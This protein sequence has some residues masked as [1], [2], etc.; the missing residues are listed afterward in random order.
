MQNLPGEIWKL[1]KAV[2]YY[3]SEQRESPW[4]AAFE[5]V[6]NNSCFFRT[7]NGICHHVLLRNHTHA[8]SPDDESEGLF[9]LS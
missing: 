4:L 8:F 6:H 7:P 2:S 3:V 1:V 9:L 5:I